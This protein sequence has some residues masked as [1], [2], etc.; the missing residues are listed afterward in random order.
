LCY[1][2]LRRLD[3]NPAALKTLCGERGRVRRQ[4]DLRLF[5]PLPETSRRTL[6]A[7]K[8]LQTVLDGDGDMTDHQSLKVVEAVLQRT[9]LRG[10]VVLKALGAHLFALLEDDHAESDVSHPA[11]SIAC[12]SLTD[13]VVAT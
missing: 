10:D 3:D 7:L 13:T 1:A 11:L 4:G 2:N 5:E 12:L 9:G 6:K 8:G